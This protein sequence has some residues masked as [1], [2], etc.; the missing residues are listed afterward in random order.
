MIGAC[1]KSPTITQTDLVG[2]WNELQPCMGTGGCI[3]LQFN[4]DSTYYGANSAGIDTG[5]YVINDSKLVLYRKGYTPLPT[6]GFPLVVHST[7]NITLKNAAPCY[8]CQQNTG[9]DIYY[10]LNLQK[11]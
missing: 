9:E 2:K 5:L 8:G 3:N 4:A 7:T 11:H 6:D 1:K 10:D